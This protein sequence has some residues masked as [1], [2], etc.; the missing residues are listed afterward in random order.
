PKTATLPEQWTARTASR[1]VQDGHWPLVNVES[2]TFPEP[3]QRFPDTRNFGI[4]DKS[5]TYE[6]GLARADRLRGG[7]RDIRL[8][9]AAIWRNSVRIVGLPLA[10]PLPAPDASNFHYAHVWK[11][12]T[13]V[14]RRSA[15]KH[16]TT[17][18]TAA[19]ATAPG[20]APASAPKGA[21]ASA[22]PKNNN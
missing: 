6:F 14:A 22:A 16:P 13:M 18:A 21:P 17:A 11:V 20:S 7:D 3:E 1:T 4:S 15:P 19:P 12:R 10:E 5:G 8:P 2:L 9:P